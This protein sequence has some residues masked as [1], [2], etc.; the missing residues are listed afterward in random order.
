MSVVIFIVFHRALTD[1]EIEYLYMYHTDCNKIINCNQNYCS[2]ERERKIYTPFLFI[3]SI[4]PILHHFV[5]IV[6]INLI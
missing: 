1:N 3:Y 4:T 2:I 5:C 6:N